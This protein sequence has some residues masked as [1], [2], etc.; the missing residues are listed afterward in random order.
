MPPDGTA[1][2][3]SGASDSGSGRRS[4]ATRAGAPSRDLACGGSPLDR[5]APIP[6]RPL[7][8]ALRLG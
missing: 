3:V 7:A 4:A 2:S 8:L 5:R 6:M 1:S